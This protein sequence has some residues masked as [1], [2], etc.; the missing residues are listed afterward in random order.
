MVY[1]FICYGFFFMI[2]GYSAMQL[3]ANICSFAAIYKQNWSGA[4]LLILCMMQTVI[5]TSK[6]FNPL[7]FNYIWNVW[8]ISASFTSFIIFFFFLVV[9]FS[10]EALEGAARTRTRNIWHPRADGL[11]RRRH[12]TH[13]LWLGALHR[14][15]WGAKW[16]CDG[17]K[18]RQR[19][20]SEKIKNK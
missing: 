17:S 18:K 2:Y 5:L 16:R 3:F 11:Q 1:L 8:Q 7:N 13:Q 14:H 20:Q 19:A 12:R 15:A 4:L 6:P 9:L 10:L